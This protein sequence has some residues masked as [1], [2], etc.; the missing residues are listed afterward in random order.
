VKCLTMPEYDLCILCSQCGSFHDVLVR[1]SLEESFELRLV[2][3]VYGAAFPP[4][5]REAICDH[6]CPTTGRALGQQD[7][8]EMLLVAVAE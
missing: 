4:H 7:P 5:F 3:D 1:V 2:S 8:G 6:E